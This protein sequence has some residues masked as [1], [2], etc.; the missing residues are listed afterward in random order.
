MAICSFVIASTPSYEK[1]GLSASIILIVC[2]LL[3]GFSSTGEIPGARIYITEITTPPQT[4]Y[5]TT[6]VNFFA[7]IGACCALAVGAFFLFIHND[8]GW[9]MAFYFGSGIA[10]VGAIARTHLRETAEFIRE[11]K[12]TKEFFS[13]KV[14]H[15]IF[16]VTE[17]RR[18]F[19][20]YLGL[21][22]IYPLCFYFSFIYLGDYLRVHH[23]FSPEQ[24]IYNN[25]F[26]AFLQAVSTFVFARLSLKIDPLFLLRAREVAFV[27]FAVMLPFIFGFATTSIHI[28][29][30]Q[31]AL[32]GVLGG[33]AKP[34]H[35]LFIRAF[36]TIGRYTQTALAFALSRAIMYIVTSYGCVFIGERF[37]LEGLSVGLALFGVMALACAFLFKPCETNSQSTE[38]K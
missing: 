20:C 7:E 10:I 18:N 26:V 6:L 35:A 2:R 8:E 28:L 37:G 12:K 36:P 1:I 11:K 22:C 13:E 9:R 27:I 19:L 21:E 34:A 4:Y 25:L 24:V 38:K 14:S 23:G 31:C 15:L 32:G 33:D 29:L 30:I 5:Y 17:Y 3:Q 16:V